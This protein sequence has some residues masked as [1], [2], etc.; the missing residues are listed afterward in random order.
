MRSALTQAAEAGEPM[1]LVDMADVDFLDSAGLAVLVTTQRA[2]RPGRC[3]A[4]YNVPPRMQRMLTVAGMEQVI[5]IHNAGDAWPF[6]D[7]PAP[8]EADAGPSVPA[9]DTTS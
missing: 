5:Q 8:P 4:L 3:L 1:L 9:S 7:V 2:L 6:P